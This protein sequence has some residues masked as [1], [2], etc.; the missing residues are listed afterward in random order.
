MYAFC[1]VNRHRIL[2]GI[3]EFG[4]HNLLNI[5]GLVFALDSSLIVLVDLTVI[6]GKEGIVAR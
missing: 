3:W 6:M 5:P 4:A 1:G 2:D